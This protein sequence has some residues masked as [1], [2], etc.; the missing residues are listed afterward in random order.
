MGNSQEKTRRR[1]SISTPQARALRKA[2]QKLKK[3]IIRCINKLRRLHQVSELKHSIDIDSIAQ[4]FANKTAKSGELDYSLNKYK[5]Q[6]LGEILF[7]CVDQFD[8]KTVVESW[9]ENTKN[10]EYSSENQEAIPFCQLVWKSSNL[11]GVGVSQDDKGETYIVANFFP[12]GNVQGKYTENVLP[13]DYS[14]VE[15]EEEPGPSAPGDRRK[16][17]RKQDLT[18]FNDFCLEAL[19]AHNEYREKHGCKDLRLNKDLCK[20]AQE[21]ADKLVSSKNPCH[22]NGTYKGKDM[23][24]NLYSCSGKGATGQGASDDWYNESKIKE[25]N[26]KKDYQKGTLNFTQMIWKGT[27]EVGF[28]VSTKGNT[29]Y[30]V[31]N[32]FPPGNFLGQFQDNVPKPKGKKD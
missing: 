14:I 25:Y 30:V 32:Y 31:A 7:S 24:E 28:G 12:A 4:A 27:T 19:K 17:L 6:E 29:S 8:A 10:Y 1:K 5:S 23:G 16:S 15:D 26:Y 9:C 13:P 3:D 21:Y 18:G 22:S 11:I 2:N 20:I